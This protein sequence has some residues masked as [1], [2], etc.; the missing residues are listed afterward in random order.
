[1]EFQWRKLTNGEEALFNKVN[2]GSEDI[3][4]CLEVFNPADKDNIIKTFGVF[5]S[6]HQFLNYIA[7]TPVMKRCYFEIIRG[8]HAQKHYV[9]ID[10]SLIDDLFTDKFPHSKEEK[11]IIAVKIV[12]LYVDVLLSLKKEISSDDILI[13]NSNGETKR[14]YHII[15]D[16]W[17]L[18]SATQNKELFQQVIE[19][20]APQYHKYFDDRMYKNIQQFRTMFSTKCG[21]NRFKVLDKQSTWKLRG[22]YP[23]EAMKV[24][25]LFYASLITEV[26]GNCNMLSFEYKEKIAYVPSRDMNNNELEIVIRTFRSKFKDASSFDIREPRNTLIPLKRRC[27]SYCEVCQRVHDSENPYLYVNFENKLF[28][29]CNRNDESQLIGS[30]N[31]GEDGSI[32]NVEGEENLVTY[33]P[34]TI[35]PRTQ[36]IQIKPFVDSDFMDLTKT[37]SESSDTKVYP[38]MMTNNS[39]PTIINETPITNIPSSKTIKVTQQEKAEHQKMIEEAKA[40]YNKPKPKGSINS[41]LQQVH[42]KIAL[43]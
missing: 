17:Y 5:R 34:P 29:N 26:T 1:M 14:S 23:N 21:K 10:I 4:V 32:T 33:I 9:D 15:V 19:K 31:M 8:S 28:F 35:Q 13:F 2:V 3:P 18:P 38:H 30:L 27:S 40:R 20:I 36:P 41:R 11:E 6:A 42:H 25:E 39:T 16:R 43:I 12:D 7:D 24:R 22:T 37:T